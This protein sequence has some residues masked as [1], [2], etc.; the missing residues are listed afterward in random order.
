[1][2]PSVPSATA[3]PAETPA[4]ETIWFMPQSAEECGITAGQFSKREKPVF[5]CFADENGKRKRIFC[6]IPVSIGGMAQ[7][8]ELEF[9]ATGSC[10]ET[11]RASATGN[12]FE[13]VVRNAAD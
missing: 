2:T 9:I 3:T 7:R 8:G 4:I 6:P 11:V 5:S 1:M 10:K 13:N 12:G